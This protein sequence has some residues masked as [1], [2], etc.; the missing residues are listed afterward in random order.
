MTKK[1]R[2]KTKDKVEKKQFLFKSG[3]K[4]IIAQTTKTVAN[5]IYLA[6]PLLGNWQLRSTV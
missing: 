4:L 5:A 6:N 3:K 2:A 1:K